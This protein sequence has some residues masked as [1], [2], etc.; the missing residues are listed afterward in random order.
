MQS[1]PAH[2]ELSANMHYSNL[3][4]SNPSNDSWAPKDVEAMG[5]AVASEG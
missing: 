3:L 1:I 5:F 4:S 2:C